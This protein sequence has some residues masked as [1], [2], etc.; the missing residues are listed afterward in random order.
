MG[1]S[2]KYPKWWIWLVCGIIAIG[3]GIVLIVDGWD[4]FE[5]LG[6][7]ILIVGG[8]LSALA[9]VLQEKQRLIVVNN[10]DGSFIFDNVSSVVEAEKYLIPMRQCLFVN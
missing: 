7:I 4:Y 3:F 5:A 10:S 6:A 1:L 9:F 8:I 2:K